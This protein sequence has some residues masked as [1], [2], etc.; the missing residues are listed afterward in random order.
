MELII[1]QVSRSKKLLQRHQVEGSMI[2][3]G[4]GYDN[5][6]ILNDPYICAHHLSLNVGED[7][8]WQ[9]CDNDTVNGS[10]TERQKPLKGCESI[11]SG[12]VISIGKSYLRFIYPHQQVAPAIRLSGLEGLLNWLSSPMVVITVFCIYIGMLFGNY[13]MGSAV[14]IKTTQM[15]SNV[16]F[17]FVVM[18]LLPLLFALLARLFKHDARVLTQM[19]VWYSF[20]IIFLLFDGLSA[21]INFNSNQSWM[22]NGFSYITQ[23]TL[24][25]SLFWATFYI[26]FH[27]SP[28]RR[29][30]TAG[31]ITI[32]IYA[33][34]YLYN[35]GN[36]SDF[37]PKPMYDNTLLAPEFAIST[38]V[39]IEQFIADSESVFELSTKKAARE[40]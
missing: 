3:I 2:N 35:A 21:L 20:F 14:E 19:V 9:V 7:G 22:S 6:V 26:A 25:F 16:F 38:P 28:M 5:D 32:G 33:L 12:D 8:R 4:R 18:S 34:S 39:S 13:Y 24:L 30:V 1:E 23:I 27:Q 36:S 29:S 15:L 17:R 11:E 10:F 31:A 40:K 37:N